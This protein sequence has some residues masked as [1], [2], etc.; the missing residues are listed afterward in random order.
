MK[1]I[2]EW[3]TSNFKT[4]PIGMILNNG[5]SITDEFEVISNKPPVVR[6]TVDNSLHY[7]TGWK[8]DIWHA[9]GNN[10]DIVVGEKIQIDN[11]EILIEEENQ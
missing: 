2:H 1:Q 3:L 4:L 11:Q 6:N 9:L 10:I 8:T 5:G 7:L